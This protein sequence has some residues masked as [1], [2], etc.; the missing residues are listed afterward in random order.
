[1]PNIYTGGTF[2]LFHEGHVEL[3]RAC[4]LLAGDG[5][6]TVALNTDEFIQRFKINP[7][8]QTYREREVVLTSCRYVDRVVPNVGEE[9]SKITIEKLMIDDKDKRAVQ[10]VAIGSDWA[11]RDYYG[12]MG[13]TKEWLDSLDITL[14]YIDRR[15][16]MSTTKIKDKLRNG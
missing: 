14:I 1:M 8:V 2:D 16:G 12:Q 6:V 3:L 4:K 10:I 15:T 9:N 7:P 5:K 11:G 13:F